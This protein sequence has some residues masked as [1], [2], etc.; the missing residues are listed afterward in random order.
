M[1]LFGKNVLIRAK[2]C[3]Y[4][5]S[6]P[7]DIPP[8]VNLY[9]KVTNRCNA[10]CRF[11][12][13][14]KHSYNRE[15]NIDKLFCVIDEV[16]HQ[17]IRVNRINITG[18]EPSM[19]AGFVER[20]L[21]KME[22]KPYLD[23]PLQLNTNGL[24][25]E[26]YTLMRHPRW[27]AISLS[28]HH[29]RK[30][31]LANIYGTEVSKTTINVEGIDRQILSCSCN[32]IRGYIDCEEEITKMMDYV[33]SLRIHNMG[34][35]VL[36]PSNQYCK[37]HYIGY[38]D[39]NMLSISGIIKT[40][41]QKNGNYC[42]CENYLYRNN[43]GALDVYIRQTTDPQYCSSSLLFDGMYLRQGFHDDNIIY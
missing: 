3:S 27:D 20:I 40:K 37:T 8:M 31:V 7:D 11:C 28:L 42:C 5:N 9:V 2:G 12:C 36:M 33:I 26:A 10:S 19:E 17:N 25:S 41:E 35:V 15:F 13:N 16:R 29:Y 38:K 24:S 1:E 14:T 18:G 23:I 22:E 21:K 32:L 4:G 30:E 43:Y 6:T 34:F 39:I